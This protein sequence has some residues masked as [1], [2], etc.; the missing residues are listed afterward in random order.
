[1]AIVNGL[2]VC[3]MLV[4]TPDLSSGVS[5]ALLNQ[6]LSFFSAIYLVFL[7]LRHASPCV[8]KISCSQYLYHSAT[9]WVKPHSFSTLLCSCCTYHSATVWGNHIITS[10]NHNVNKF[11]RNT[12]E[13]LL[14]LQSKPVHVF[15]TYVPFS[16]SV[17]QTVFVQ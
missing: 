13:V 12:P 4:I 6:S 2:C 11:I 9:V 8:G 14:H 5:W 1:M 16:N 17:G 3:C 10:T 15:V 7:T